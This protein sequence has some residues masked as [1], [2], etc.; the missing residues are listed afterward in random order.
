MTRE[1]IKKWWDD[2]FGAKFKNSATYRAVE[3][4]LDQICDAH[5]AELKAKDERIEAQSSVII[6]CQNTILQKDEHITELEAERDKYNTIAANLQSS[7]GKVL[8]YLEDL[9]SYI[10]AQIVECQKVIDTKKADM[11]TY[12][13]ADGLRQAYT[14]ILQKIRGEQ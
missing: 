12:Y 4:K 1:E 10:E 5:E 13:E 8:M 9:E 6:A 7:R 11:F 3:E 14:D 2:L